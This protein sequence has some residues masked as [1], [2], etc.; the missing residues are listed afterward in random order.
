MKKPNYIL[1]TAAFNEDKNIEKTITAVISQTILPSLWIL[2]SDGSNDNTDHIIKTYQNK[3]SFIEYMRIEKE[4]KF[5]FASKVFALHEGIKKL[6][7]KEFEYVGILDAD[8]T[9]QNNYYEEILARFNQ[10]QKLGIAGGNIVEFIHDTYINRIKTLISVAGAVQFFRKECFQDIGQFLPLEYGG[11][12]AA[13]EITAR[14][15]GWRVKTFP[16]L[17]V[18]HHGY[19]GGKRFLRNRYRRGIQLFL[20]GYHPIFLATRSLYRFRERPFFAGSIAEMTGYI[21]AWIK[22]KKPLLP[23]DVVHFLRNEQLQRL[24]DLLPF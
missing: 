1:I 21:K 17:I 8:I 11:E 5:S 3:Y 14:M 13:V 4:N 18:I 16:E 10:D 9:F 19:V 12:D 7:N 23:D 20:L 6:N 2:I 24:K 22:Y 15:K